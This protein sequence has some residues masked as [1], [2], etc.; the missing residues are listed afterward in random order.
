[1]LEEFKGSVAEGVA[2]Q[3]ET[4]GA[5]TGAIQQMSSNASAPAPASSGDNSDVVAAVQQLQR[6]LVSQGIKVK[7]SGSWF[8]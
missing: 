7:S 6:A 2:A 1:M 5:I 4:G 3:T 8:S